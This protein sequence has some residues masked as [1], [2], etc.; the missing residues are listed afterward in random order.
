MFLLCIGELLEE[1]THKEVRQRPCAHHVFECRQ[2]MAEEGTAWRFF[3]GAKEVREGDEVVV[4]MGNVIPFD[5]V[6]TDGEAMVNQA[7]LTGESEPVRRISE[8]LCLCRNCSRGRGAY[9]SREGGR[10]LQPL[11]QRLFR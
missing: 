2:S 1:W 4:H 11:R 3:V 10:R 9:H 5:G 7:S 6:V 8:E